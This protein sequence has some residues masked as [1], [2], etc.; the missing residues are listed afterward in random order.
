RLRGDRLS[1]DTPI[2]VL[3]DRGDALD[4]ETLRQL[5]ADGQME[6]DA[7]TLAA[8]LSAF[9][10][11]FEGP[12][13]DRIGEGTLDELAERLADEMRR[14]IASAIAGRTLQLD[15]GDGGEM[16]AAAWNAVA[17]VRE[18]L[19]VRVGDRVRYRDDRGPTF[20]QLESSAG[21]LAA[22]TLEPAAGDVADL[23]RR[24]MVVADDDP[25][26]RWFFCELLA[27]AG[28]E[29]HEAED[30]AEALALIERHRPH[31]V[32]ADVVMP[33]LDGLAL[34]RELS[35]D[36]ELA[37]IPVILL[38][39][40]PTFSNER[41][42]FA[43]PPRAFARKSS[44][45]AFSNVPNPSLCRVGDSKRRWR[46]PVRAA[47]GSKAWACTRRSNSC[48]RPIPMRA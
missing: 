23:A 13:L 14:G 34:C 6:R 25:A 16:L 33:E 12:R 3:Y 8:R 1:A 35:D 39:W 29:V 48:A 32:F 40:K 7:A 20:V 44:R 10:R 17:E 26:I 46:A 30:G 41:R 27:E 4:G 11:N 5:G 24:I 2:L 15:L 45:S 36:P 18:A 38:S 19:R 9:L 31:L 43:T 28:A 42:S 37:G 47:A 21:T 22:P